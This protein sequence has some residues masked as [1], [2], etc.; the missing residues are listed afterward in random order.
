CRSTTVSEDLAGIMFGQGEHPRRPW[1]HF[2]PSGKIWQG[3]LDARMYVS[4]DVL[5]G[6]GKEPT[7]QLGEGREPELQSQRTLG[8]QV[9]G[10]MGVDPGSRVTPSRFIGLMAQQADSFG[11]TI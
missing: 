7:G 6:M 2:I 1:G 5:D 9:G 3:L 11:L 8:I 10:G 4:M